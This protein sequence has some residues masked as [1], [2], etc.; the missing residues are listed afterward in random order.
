MG[1]LYLDE[2]DVEPEMNLVRRDL[3][4]L[5]HGVKTEATQFVARDLLVVNNPGT[6]S[7]PPRCVLVSLEVATPFQG[8]PGFVGHGLDLWQV[9]P[10]TIVL[11]ALNLYV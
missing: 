10:H 3:D 11:L 8:M 1:N 7:W 5:R 2:C 4:C 6:S 9:L